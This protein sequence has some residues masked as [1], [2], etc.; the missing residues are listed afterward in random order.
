MQDT[1]AGAHTVKS[2]K[3]SPLYASQIIRYRCSWPQCRVQFLS[4][5]VAAVSPLMVA[6]KSV[7]ERLRRSSMLPTTGHGVGLHE[8]TVA[9]DQRSGRRA[10]IVT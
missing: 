6:L 10:F 8:V 9:R 7:A 1:R 3:S 4:L 2:V 5:T